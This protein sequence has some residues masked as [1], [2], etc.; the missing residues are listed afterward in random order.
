MNRNAAVPALIAAL[1]LPCGIGLADEPKQDQDQTR[2]QDQTRSQ[3]R[4]RMH[5]SEQ[6]RIYGS[7]LMTRKERAEYRERIRAAKTEEER[8]R[9]RNEHHEQMQARAKER[10]V[11]LPDKPPATRGHKGR[12]NGMGPGG[13]G[14]GGGMGPGGG[15]MGGGMG[16]R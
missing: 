2:T 15:G 8:E 6:E 9:I 3:D 7:Q 5:Q 12:G 16:G 1:L 13:G 11:K 14:M 10:G 4:T